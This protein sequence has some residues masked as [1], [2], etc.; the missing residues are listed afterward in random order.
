MCLVCLFPVGL[1]ATYWIAAATR[2]V[3]SLL[4]IGCATLSLDYC[5]KS[6]KVKFFSY[7]CRIRYAQCMFLRTGNSGLYHTYAFHC[8]EQL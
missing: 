5:Y 3:Y 1:E 7:V 8:L 4:F 2:V 6:D